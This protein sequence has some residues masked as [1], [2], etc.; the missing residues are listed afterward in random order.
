MGCAVIIF[1]LT[2]RIL[3]LPLTIAS[4]RTRKERRQIEDSLNETRAHYENSP[5]KLKKN[6][7]QIFASNRRVLISETVNFIIQ[8]MIF[9]ILYRIFT[10][11]LLGA[12]FHLLYSF[13][14]PIQDGFNLVFLNRFDLTHS[15]LTLN[16]IQSLTIVAVEAIS[17]MDS[18]F[19]VTRNDIMR[20]L[21]SLP[22]AS[23]LIFMFLPAG[24]KIFI[25]TTLWFSFFYTLINMLIR[26]INILM[27][28]L[29]A[30]ASGTPAGE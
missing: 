30:K 3:M 17:L 16:F 10:T 26:Q 7:K 18:P 25:I 24:K 19:P 4:T 2:I 27:S 20:Y 13:M 6:I 1:T 23:F 12:D 29:P 14:P 11:G 28:P 8:M 22:V 15:N 21:I 9:F 5:E